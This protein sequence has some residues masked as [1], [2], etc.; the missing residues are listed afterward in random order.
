[1]KILTKKLCGFIL[2]MAMIC[3]PTQGVFAAS[4]PFP[5]PAG[6]EDILS[7]TVNPAYLD[8]NDNQWHY[9]TGSAHTFYQTFSSHAVFPT[10][11]R[12]IGNGVNYSHFRVKIEFNK[13][14]WGNYTPI[15]E[16]ERQ[17]VIN[18]T[19]AGTQTYICYLKFIPSYASKQIQFL[20]GTDN[21][22]V[23]ITCKF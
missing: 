18:A 10:F 20:T 23:R 22:T 2:I 4:D 19:S 3:I 6:S 16:G 13:K 17:P 11:D 7:V 8:S 12:S 1:M 14:W 21:P 9:Y 5:G 15:I